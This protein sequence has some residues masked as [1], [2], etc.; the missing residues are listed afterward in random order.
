MTDVRN[1]QCSCGCETEVRQGR[2]YR[3]GHDARHVSQLAAKV[4]AGELTAAKAA[5]LLGSD[6]LRAKLARSLDRS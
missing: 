2:R 6:A 1:L 5:K 4:R 3:Q